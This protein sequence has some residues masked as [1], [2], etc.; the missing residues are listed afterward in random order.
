MGLC[1]L[2]ATVISSACVDE[3]GCATATFLPIL[4]IEFRNKTLSH[5]GIFPFPKPTQPKTTT[6]LSRDRQFDGSSS[7]W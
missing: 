5:S 2:A 4:H 6:S 1:V 7:N 3:N